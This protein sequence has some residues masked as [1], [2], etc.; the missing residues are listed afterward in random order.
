[1]LCDNGEGVPRD[2]AEAAKWYR[3]EADQGDPF[4]QSNL[5]RRYYE[6]QGVPQD[7]AE[8]AQ[9]YCMAAE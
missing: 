7:Y 5:A 4:A 8:A 3:M 9:W 6:G 1:M 2:Y